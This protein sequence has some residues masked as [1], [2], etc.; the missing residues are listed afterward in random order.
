MQLQVREDQINAITQYLSVTG[1]Y[2]T[3]RLGVLKTYYEKEF[4][5]KSRD[6]QRYIALYEEHQLAKI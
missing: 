3:F 2:N 4:D 5:P 6:I 1:V